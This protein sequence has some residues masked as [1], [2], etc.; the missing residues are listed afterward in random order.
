[1]MF[2]K[3]LLVLGALFAG[4]AFAQ[5]SFSVY[6]NGESSTANCHVDGVSNAQL[7]TNGSGNLVATAATPLAFSSACG[8][9]GSAQQLTF[10]PGQPL[11]GPTTT[12]AAGSNVVGNFTVLPLNAT[13]CTVAIVTTSGTGVATGPASGYVCGPSG[14]QSCAPS[15]PIGF[16]ASF[17]NTGTGASAYQATV[18]CQAASGASPAA[19]TSQATVNQSG[20]SGGTP[21]A[22]FTF[23]TS[24]LTANFTDTSTDPGGTLSAWSWNFGDSTSSTTPSPSHTYAAAG[25]Y[26][27]SLTVTDSVSSAQNTKTQQVTVTASSGNCLTNASATAGISNY[28][29]W[30]GIQ[31]VYY[32]GPTYPVDVTSFNS[33]YGIGTAQQATW[34]GNTSLTADFDLPTNKYISLQFTVPAGFMET[35]VSGGY[36][37]NASGFS[38]PISMTISDG[39]APC[40]DFSDPVTNPTSKVISGCWKNLMG[41][42]GTL[43][44][45][46]TGGTKCLLQDNHTYFLNMINADISNANP[47][48]TASLTSSKT[49]SCGTSCGD[50]VRNK[51]VTYK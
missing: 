43:A 3:V 41:S 50:P 40:G 49:T 46:G 42:S 45:Q 2:R 4:N 28:T 15:T 36:G 44:W 14:A 20:N 21:A 8:I 10:G 51:P 7:S 39:S 25:T 35:V 29:R 34:P 6:F 27:V 32:F 37:L 26:T 48:G 22:N 9:S 16:N 30:T 38:A 18:T 17:T 24:N 12:L 47:A 5:G 31:N 19:L 11:K 23:T 1:M 33:V 13:A